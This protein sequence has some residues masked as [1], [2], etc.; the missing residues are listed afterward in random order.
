MPAAYG[1]LD[2]LGP[3]TLQSR[4][5]WTKISLQ[6]ILLKLV[7]IARWLVL[8]RLGVTLLCIHSWY[9]FTTDPNFWSIA[10]RY[11]LY[12]YTSSELNLSFRTKIRTKIRTKKC[13]CATSISFLKSETRT[14]IAGSIA[15]VVMAPAQPCI[16]T[17]AASAVTSQPLKP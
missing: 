10:V 14:A 15:M 13:L 16:L 4:T 12:G 2:L 11:G 1:P 17:C 3:Q 9:R 8:S 6:Y 7:L 5:V